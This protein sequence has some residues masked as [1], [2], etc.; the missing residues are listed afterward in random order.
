MEDAFVHSHSSRLRPD[1]VR[2]EVITRS[3]HLSHRHSPP[4]ALQVDVEET[5]LY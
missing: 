2:C 4:L 5:R 3:S 1:S